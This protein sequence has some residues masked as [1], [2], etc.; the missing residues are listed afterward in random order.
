MQLLQPHR[1][2]RAPKWRRYVILAVV[3]AT[4]VGLWQSWDHLHARYLR[5]KQDR[6][7][8]QAKHFIAN[9]D[10]PNAQIALDVALRALPGNPEALRTAADMLEQVGAPQAMR[11]RRAVTQVEPDSAEDA[12]KLV[13]CCLRFNDING[14]RDALS[15]TSHALSVQDPMVKAAL[16]F[17]LA[18]GN[19]PVADAL[20]RDLE[21]R[22]P[23][24]ED[25]QHAHALLLLQHPKPEK[26]EAAR[27]ELLHLADIN[28]KLVLTI[29]RELIGDAFRRRDYEEAREG[30]KQLLASPEATLNDRLQLAN[31]QLLVD[32]EPI[33][34]ILAQLEP[35]AAGNEPDAVQFTQWLLVQNRPADADRWIGTLPQAIRSSTALVSLQADVAAQLKDWD[36]LAILL[37]AGAWGRVPKDTVRL[38]FAALTVDN[39]ARRSLRRQTW[40]MTLDAAAG[41]LI[42]LRLLQRLAALWQWPD[43][44]E[45]TLWA[46]ARGFPDQT[47]AHQALFNAYRDR[48][49]TV[50]MRDVMSALRDSDGSVPRYQYDWA[51]LTLLT[52]PTSTW[53]PAKDTL[54][55]LYETE[56]GNP[57]YATGYAFALAQTGKG[58][59][60]LAVTQ[61]LSNEELSYP[62]RQPYLA[63]V[64]GV[65][66]QAN[67]V[68]E[69][70]ARGQ[71]AN[72]LPEENYLFTRAQEELNRKPEKSKPAKPAGDQS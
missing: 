23:G 16:A 66:R 40:E 71:G 48:K 59:E 26:R 54:R 68:A 2:K 35:I 42:S 33:E 6:A 3:A 29:R 46:I 14:A 47:W 50:R 19:S 11:L 44:S 70:T 32:R 13:L 10:A 38:A 8:R 65:A 36:R 27:K 49:D 69:A 53:N 17:A 22:H 61:K 64:Y 45:L 7:L 39:P 60:A 55:K 15:S 52:D 18:T 58:A 57:S 24:D 31:L 5:W 30:L 51:L 20:L 21:A 41:D 1:T 37:Q 9:R 28:P 62:P 56:A 72:Y 12:A 67:G 34:P 4:G 43:E 25:V 63:F